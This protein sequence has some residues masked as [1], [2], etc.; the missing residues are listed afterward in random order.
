MQLHA[1]DPGAAAIQAA[2]IRRK[3][4]AAAASGLEEPFERSRIEAAIRTVASGF[5]GIVGGEAAFAYRRVSSQEIAR[6]GDYACWCAFET[7]GRPI[8]IA[9]DDATTLAAAHVAL[10]KSREHAIGEQASGVD[11]FIA[12][13]FA[14]RLAVA[15]AASEPEIMKFS[16]GKRLAITAAY[17]ELRLDGIDGA[18][19]LFEFSELTIC[20]DHRLR[21]LIVCPPLASREEAGAL[22]R[23]A[24]RRAA[25]SRRLSPHALA[26]RINLVARIRFAKM[27]FSDVAAL[28][29]G[30]IINGESADSAVQL[31]P[32][33]SASGKPF[34]EG[35][36]GRVEKKRA[37]MIACDSGVDE[38][39]PIRRDDAGRRAKNVA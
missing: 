7:E 9:F 6:A 39:A 12:A 3:I 25:A 18:A 27:V 10:G 23:S 24:E 32:I 15:H 20:G 36:I 28:R 31:V 8:L 22:L 4:A 38:H 2:L 13:V 16:V 30:D 33:C 17:S 34:C 14:K 1:L 37:I 26:A 11:R 5:F 35:V 19:D 29:P 21:F